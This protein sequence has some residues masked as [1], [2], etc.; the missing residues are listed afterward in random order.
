[1]LAWLSVWSEVQTWVWPSWCHCHS[2]SLASVKSRLVLPFWYRLT[3][4]VPEKGLCVCV[5][6]SDKNEENNHRWV[7]LWESTSSHDLD[8]CSAV[9]GRCVADL[10]NDLD[11]MS[12][13]LQRLVA[14]HQLVVT[15]TDR[16]LHVHHPTADTQAHTHKHT[17]LM[18]LFT[19]LPGWSGTRR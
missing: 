14:Y 18:A 5:C 12:D 1:M 13:L 10:A 16:L 3:R 11:A 8:Q 7:A 9:D 2:L 15:V 4:V 6:K 19:G 17:R